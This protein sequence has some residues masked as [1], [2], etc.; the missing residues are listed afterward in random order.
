MK[1]SLLLPTRFLRPTASRHST[2]AL[3]ADPNR[4]LS[5]PDTKI[6]T[7]PSGL[8]VATEERHGETASVG[9]WIDAGSRYE[10]AENNGAAHFLEHLAFKGTKRR[11]QQG[12]EVEIENMGA[13][14][15]AYTSREQ[16][17][18][19]AK[20]FKQDVGKAMDVL[21]DILL[22][23]EL[24]GGSV[25]RE[26]G[27]IVREMEEVSRQ[28]EEVIMDYLH[29]AAYSTSGLGMTILG[30]EQNINSL[31]QHQFRAYIDTHYTAPRMVICGVGAVDHDELVELSKTY[32]DKDLPSVPRTSY[33]TNFDPAVF[34]AGEV[35]DNKGYP[36]LE[37]A[38]VS[39]AFEGT[40]WTAPNASALMVVQA[41]LGT[42]DRL[43]GAGARV[44][45]L[46]AQQLAE[47]D[48]CHSF[49][50]LNISYKDTGLFGIYLIGEEETMPAALEVVAQNVK[51][52]ATPG[53]VSEAELNRA[54]TQLKASLMQQLN[55]FSFV[56]EDI[57][58]QVLTY[59]RRM[60]PVETFARIDAVTLA[61]VTDTS[62]RFVKDSATESNS[63]SN[64]ST[65][66]VCSE[67]GGSS[68]RRQQGSLALAALGKIGKLPDYAWVDGLFVK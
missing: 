21:S 39:V 4:L 63:S 14:L 52:L 26:R 12:L 18:Y 6:T 11:T 37:V 24:A 60:P 59:G 50:T 30:P 23:S 46:L 19:F 35:R 17:V 3:A 5:A 54:K 45:S 15:N 43:S 2:A 65:G 1:R 36:D 51:R 34:G 8:R 13:H 20:C 27:V 10:T 47:K 40:S 62:N 44:P 68:L 41:M 58:R 33:P 42:W 29:E 49:N 28:H 31:K 38:H 57:G 61:D 25:E 9:V 32:W 48:L 56:A 55:T 53:A 64:S 22:H 16:T 67:G 66:A 7:L